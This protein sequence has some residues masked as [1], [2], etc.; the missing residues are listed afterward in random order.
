MHSADVGKL[1]KRSILFIIIE[2]PGSN[3]NQTPGNSAP[4]IKTEKRASKRCI[5]LLV[6]DITKVYF[7]FSASSGLT[8]SRIFDRSSQIYIAASLLKNSEGSDPQ[9][10]ESSAMNAAM[11]SISWIV[12][13]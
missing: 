11:E 2:T 3:N 6:A 1:L 9:I 8:A 12:I 13:T 4:G 7:Q 10:R 5:A